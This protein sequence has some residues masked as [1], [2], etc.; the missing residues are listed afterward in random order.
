M[1]KLTFVLMLLAVG[2]LPARADENGSSKK[3]GYVMIDPD[4]HAELVRIHYADELD[5]AAISG[6]VS[7]VTGSGCVIG[8]SWGEVPPHRPDG[9]PTIAFPQGRIEFRMENGKTKFYLTWIEDEYELF[10]IGASV[11]FRPPRKSKTQRR[12]KE[13]FPVTDA[14]RRIPEHLLAQLCRNGPEIVARGKSRFVLRQQMALQ[15]QRRAQEHAEL[16]GPRWFS[17][18]KRKKAV[19][20]PPLRLAGDSPDSIGFLVGTREGDTRE[21]PPLR[22]REPP[23][24]LREL[25]DQVYS[26]Q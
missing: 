3:R 10:P 4:E 12:V 24:Q 16:A 19:C 21:L 9:S 26:A 8:R 11:E 23:T 7:W 22:L 2:T 5:L 14:K 15:Q 17:K 18:G 1:K 25:P 20:I 6:T 13:L